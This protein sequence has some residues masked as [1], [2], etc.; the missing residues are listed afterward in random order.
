MF[1]THRHTSRSTVC[2]KG[3]NL[4]L[5][6]LYPASCDWTDGKQHPWG[7][8]FQG[9]GPHGCKAILK[10]SQATSSHC[11]LSPRYAAD[12]TDKFWEHLRRVF[13]VI[14][15]TLPTLIETQSKNSCLIALIFNS[16]WIACSCLRTVLGRRIDS[17]VSGLLR[18]CPT[19]LM[20]LSS[21]QSI[22]QSLQ[23]WS[24]LMQPKYPTSFAIRLFYLLF[25][26]SV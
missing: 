16:C 7:C 14:F 4:N 22:I 10:H 25:V 12:G 9:T 21:W 13:N 26:Y 2:N 15:S 6:L 23:T 5:V 19:I 8:Y 17:V 20:S 3:I 18:V 11:K 1:K 24:I